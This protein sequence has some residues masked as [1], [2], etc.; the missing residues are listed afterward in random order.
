MCEVEG[1]P[2]YEV[3]LDGEA[4]SIQYKFDK[5][6]IDFGTTFYDKFQKEE[7]TLFNMGK[8]KFDFTVNFDSVAQPTIIK[9]VPT[10]QVVGPGEKCKIQIEIYPGLPTFVTTSFTVEVA[11]F[12]PQV[13]VVTGKGM[14]PHVSVNLPRIDPANYAR[15]LQEAQGL[16]GFTEMDGSETE[17][18][19]GMPGMAART[20][21]THASEVTE[22]LRSGGGLPD[23]VPPATA[24]T[25]RISS[26]GGTANGIR[27]P[28][29]MTMET[30]LET[31]PFIRQLQAEADCVGMREY[32]VEQVASKEVEEEA[33]RARVLFNEDAERKALMIDLDEPDELLDAKSRPGTGN[34]GPSAPPGPGA[35]DNAPPAV[36]VFK[37]GAPFVDMRN[38]VL[39]EYVCDFGHVIR[40]AQ[41]QRTFRVT[42]VGFTNISFEYPKN[43]KSA[44]IAAGFV[45]E[46][47]RVNRLPGAP[48]Y[49]SVEFTVLFNSG[50]PGVNLGPVDLLIP[51][52]IRG[53]PQ[54]NV[55]LK[56]NVTIPDIDLSSDNLKFGAVFC[57]HSRH[58]TVQLTN[59][60]EIPATWSFTKALQQENKKWGDCAD[61]TVIPNSGT[62]NPGEACNVQVVFHP[63][64]SQTYVAKI[65]IKIKDNPTKRMVKISAQSEN[66]AIRFDPPLLDLNPILPF[67]VETERKVTV[68]NNTDARLEFFSL[69]F[70]EQYKEEESILRRVSIYEASKVSYSDV[71][72]LPLRTPQSSL[73]TDVLQAW[74]PIF[75]AEEGERKAAE[76]ARI[77]AEEKAEAARLR[78]EGGEEAAAAESE[79][80]ADE[81]PQG[82]AEQARSTPKNISPVD[83]GGTLQPLEPQVPSVTPINM[84]VYGHP[85]AAPNRVAKGL[86][87]KYKMAVLDLQDMMA[88]YMKEAGISQYLESVPD[89]EA[90]DPDSAPPKLVPVEGT[91][92]LD[93]TAAPVGA[94]KALQEIFFP[95]LPPPEDTGEDAEPTPTEEDAE[96]DGEE[97]PPPALPPPRLEQKEDGWMTSQLLCELIKH[98]LMEMQ[99]VRGVVVSGLALSYMPEAL[100]VAK[101]VKMA[102]SSKSLQV[103][104]LE[105][106]EAPEEAADA[107]GGEAAPAEVE[108]PATEEEKAHVGEE[109]DDEGEEGLEEEQQEPEQE[110]QEQPEVE[111]QPTPYDPYGPEEVFDP[112]QL[113]EILEKFSAEYEVIK[114]YFDPPPKEEGE[115][116]APAEEEEEK[117]EIL[118]PTIF[119]ISRVLRVGKQALEDMVIE[120]MTRLPEPG[121][122]PG[123]A[124]KLK[125]PPVMDREIVVRPTVRLER[126]PVNNFY[127]L[128]PTL[129][130]EEPPGDGEEEAPAPE[131]GEEPVAKGPQYTY[132]RKT[133][134]VIEARSSIELVV[135]F[136]ASDT[137]R[138]ESM[139]A[140]EVMGGGVVMR[141]REFSLPC[142][143]TCAYPQMSQNY[144][145]IYYRK[146]KQKA[147]GQI[148]SK[149]FIVNKNMYEFGPLLVGRSKE[150]H[151]EKYLESKDMFRITNSG[152]FD[153]HVDFCFLNDQSGKVFMVEPES[154]DL[155]VDET[156]DITVYAFPEEEGEF[157]DKLICNIK[158]NPEPVEM[159]MTCIGNMPKII[160]DLELQLDEEGN[161]IEGAPLKVDF[162][163]L[164]LKRK[165]TRIVT[166]KNTSLLPTKWNLVGCSEEDGFNCGKEFSISPVTGM[167]M[168]GQSE[169]ITIGFHA[170]EK[171]TFE[172]NVV[173]EWIDLDDLLPEKMKLPILVT[174]EA[175]EIDFTFTFPEGDGIDFGILKVEEGGKQSFTIAN[176][177]KYTVGYKFNFARPK[178]SMVAKYFTIENDPNPEDP[179]YKEDDPHGKSYGKLEPGTEANITIMFSS[180]NFPGEEEVNI[181]DNLELKCYVSELLT[182]EEIF[183]N[184]IKLNVR[185]VFSKFRILPQK[186]IS[187]G[188]LTYDTQKTRTF[189]IINQGEFEFEFKIECITGRSKGMRPMTAAVKSITDPDFKG[190]EVGD[191]IKIGQFVVR[192]ASGTVAPS[193]EKQT[194]TVEFSAEGEASF[195]EVL[196]VQISQRDPRSDV[197]DQGMPYEITAES[198][199]PGILNNE[200]L[201][202]FEEAS[203]SRKAPSDP[204][205]LVHNLFIEEERTLYFGPRLVN[206]D[207]QVRVKIVNPTKV[208]ITVNLDMKD[209]P[210]APNAFEVL[211]PKQLQIPMHEHRY[212]TIFFKPTGLQTFIGSFEANVELGTE[213]KTNSL[214]FEVRG[215]GTLP[216]VSILQP[217]HRNDKGQA[218]VSFKRLLKG[219]T[220]TETILVKNE[221]ILPANLRF[222]RLAPLPGESESGLNGPESFTFSGRGAEILLKAKEEKRYDV[223]FMP[224]EIGKL[225]AGISMVVANNEFE[226]N[227]IELEGEGFMQDTSIGN[228][229]EGSED[230]LIFGNLTVGV[231]KQL[232][233]TINNNSAKVYRFKWLKEADDTYITF[234]PQEGHLQPGQSKDVTATVLAKKEMD[235]QAGKPLVL[236]TTEITYPDGGATDWDDSIKDVE[237]I[238][239]DDA[240]DQT[241]PDSPQRVGRR[242]PK[243]VVK[244][245]PEPPYQPVKN[246]DPPEEG[247][248][249][250]RENVVEE[251]DMK[252]SF[253]ADYIRYAYLIKNESGEEEEALTM[254]PLVF[255]ETMMYRE[256]LHKFMFKNTCKS[257]MSY[258]WRVCLTDG[259]EDLDPENPFSIEPANG[260]LQPDETVEITVRFAPTEVD[261][262]ERKV[263]CDIPN[264]STRVE[265][266]VAAPPAEGEEEAPPQEEEGDPAPDA[267]AQPVLEISGK[268]A[269]PLC[270]LELEESDWL[271]G[272]RRPPTLTT[273]GGKPVDPTSRCIEF[274][275]LGTQ[276]RNTRRFFVMNPTNISY[277]YR[278]ECEDGTGAAV[279]HLSA[280]FKCIH[281]EGFVLSGMKSEMVFEYVPDSDQLLESFWRFVIPEHDISVP[282]ILVG[283]VKEPRVFF[284]KTFCNFN[285]LLL[286]H[287]GVQSVKLVNKEHIPFVFNFDGKTYGANE[288]PQVVKIT[289]SQGTIPPEGEQTI[290]VE[291]TPRTE[292]SYNYNAVCLVK[293]KAT[294]LAL[295]IKG[296]GFDNHASITMEDERGTTEVLPGGLT[297]IDFGEVHL[298]EMRQKIVAVTNKGKYPIEYD[299]QTAKNRMLTIKPPHGIVNKGERQEVKFV[300]QPMSASHVM[301]DHPV[302][303]KIINGPRFNL[304]V[305]ARGRRPNLNFSLMKM[306]FGSCFLYRQGA[307][308][309]VAVLRLTNEDTQDISYDAQFDNKPWLE[310]D[311]PPTNLAPGQ[312]EEIK[313]VFMPRE[314]KTYSEVI[315]F[316]INGLIVVNV[317]ITGSGHECDIAIANPAQFNYN[318]GAVKVGTVVD[319]RIKVKNNSPVLAECSIANSVARLAGIDI[320]IRPSEFSL[321]PKETIELELSY[322][323]QSRTMPF[324][325]DVKVIISGVEK[326]LMVV[327]GSAVGVE[328]KLESDML[329]FGAVV[330]NSRAKRVIQ[331]ENIGDIGTKW[332]WAADAFNPDFS[333]DPVEGFLNPHD[334]VSLEFTFHPAYVNDDCRRD[335]VP[336]FIDGADPLLMTT[337]GICVSQEPNEQTLTFDTPVRKPASQQT[338][339]ITNK[340]D[341][342]WRLIPVVDNKYWSAPEILEIPA[343]QS[344]GCTLTYTPH[345]MTSHM[346]AEPEPVE[347]GQPPPPPPSRPRQHTGSVFIPLPDGTAVLY[348]LT[349]TAG[350]PEQEGET[351][352]RDVQCK[353]S[354]MEPLVVRNWLNRPQR[355]TVKIEPPPEGTTTVKG[356]TYIDVPA[357]AERAYA[358][359]FHTYV[360]GATEVKVTLTNEETGE[361]MFYNVV[362]TAIAPAVLRSFELSTV[363]R[364]GKSLEIDLANP[365]PQAV[366]MAAKCDDTDIVL[367]PQYE[368]RASGETPCKIIYRP[369][370]PT[371]DVKATNVTFSSSELGDFV[372]EL[373]LKASKA[374]AD[375][376]MQFK[377]SIGS[378]QTLTFRF[379]HFLPSDCTYECS[380]DSQMFTVGGS[381]SA[382]AAGPEGVEVEVE[383]TFDPDIIGECNAKLLVASPEG[384]EYTC[385]LNGHGLAPRPQGPFEVSGSYTI[386]FKNPFKDSKSFTVAVDNPAFRTIA[387]LPDVSGRSG[388]PF[389]VSYSGAGSAAIQ[390]KLTVTC[391][392][393]PPW[394]YYLKGV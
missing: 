264:L 342:P 235:L 366:V 115:E 174:A 82:D 224:K 55:Y 260:N 378:E 325:E 380:T 363:V 119:K 61:F 287:K 309:N 246:G 45:V 299:L 245:R 12:E 176:N 113:P 16:L 318:L 231:P 324:S 133:R 343:G 69:D 288:D 9:A 376:S 14:F 88:Q 125:I 194:I 154:L 298:N 329:F 258:S 204:N 349:G 89:E 175:Y 254:P 131:D 302:E 84:L 373:R 117:K 226:S 93:A 270:H 185:S 118:A 132:A 360:E 311:A 102:L 159:S 387:S 236:E 81:D 5:T 364:Q 266:P 181:R 101:S 304:N 291:F 251:V 96:G 334:E 201:Q 208:P 1:G 296:E 104:F 183:G 83:A 67:V 127:I 367:E 301:Q 213:P 244:H 282:F 195:F 77:K 164:L 248:E 143:G 237:W 87:Y 111:R 62:L 211:E 78:A 170:I 209:K 377:S 36:S 120:L 189:D 267:Q 70:D 147:E 199:I 30:F 39:S 165:D 128:T 283:H 234:S 32:I 215:D 21:R 256:R 368:L 337:T 383:V 34:D 31:N 306:D 94:V 180:K 91:W 29:P 286:D 50:R 25:Q 66:L 229:P 155:A 313:I 10:T 347:E 153:M 214:V 390:A 389:S 307:L 374:G 57:G 80:A 169:E 198:C 49:E 210:G 97:K 257:T 163:R 271:S 85:L 205:E 161:A 290:T 268:S 187:F 38:F 305:S 218:L 289:P 139:L 4:S 355:F 372:Y 348:N 124:R 24:G 250:T 40:G 217:R 171:E 263:V 173:L 393:F 327:S 249:D 134:W 46:P 259:Q 278:W 352:R 316:M 28:P 6:S 8:V 323:P 382:P 216:R 356:A 150:D 321:R 328:L 333:V 317:D 361:Y 73:Q 135:K 314:M 340:T 275:S 68:Y 239:E 109:F 221:G 107:G 112:E 344:L 297:A 359:R 225:R 280:A 326:T 15:F 142:R 116:A 310:V 44:L 137:G 227:T 11:H 315:P 172:K 98:R 18:T 388:A 103:I 191:G 240:L 2:E 144:Q 47:D 341:K 53:G 303:L 346:D 22:A 206:S 148:V 166:I 100:D 207:S 255:A 145:S 232:S 136:K 212:A 330:A 79:P 152:L 350:P 354:F 23:G 160:T 86:A 90:E 319:R 242:R 17:R 20:H 182:G 335:N 27:A 95:P 177:G 300:F 228:L 233:F 252:V 75:E 141:G 184:P 196:G 158:D 274:E 52:A 192:P 162:S 13:V 130:P 190:E 262:F 292:R 312:S 222:G 33:R 43:V 37:T 3:K 140:F 370:L 108:P 197:P 200:F 149:Q 285:S 230:T 203:V 362:F 381:V 26:A 99:Y 332:R 58:V 269:R 365:L 59:P 336:L 138:F 279:A 276:V 351:I 358:L 308:P 295:N 151:K 179:D 76:E 375:R 277:K 126:R 247:E 71:V 219:K 294:R 385:I 121:A 129:V 386:N 157:T 371:E 281:K 7:I 338:P 339:T 122:V 188:A 320:N 284:D 35:P 261:H 369:M 379:L 223:T 19:E 167:L 64:T 65:P 92:Q 72:L 105:H 42:N 272:G 322:A 178:R 63:R 110:E 202:I 48:D 123:E 293:K 60:K 357:K 41:L 193:G 391:E 146:M 106:T 156:A 243:K 392:G 56:A 265:K 353:A 253:A 51:I 54:V 238:T 384:G 74:A 220:Q 345:A 114:S 186:G 273:P 331:L 241:S 168:P 394:L